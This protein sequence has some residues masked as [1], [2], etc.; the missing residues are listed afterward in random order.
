MFLIFIVGFI[1]DSTKKIDVLPDEA[2]SLDV[3]SQA[4]VQGFERELIEAVGV[5]TKNELAENLFYFAKT[6]YKKYSN[7]DVPVGFLVESLE[8][9]ENRIEISGRFGASKNK[10]KINGDI[11]KNGKLYLSIVDTKTSLSFNASLPANSKRNQFIGKLPI[12]Q[13]T[14][15]ILYDQIKDS[16]IGGSNFAL[17]IIEV[18]KVIKESL[19][20]ADVSEDEIV[21]IPGG[22]ADSSGVFGGGL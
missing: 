19:G 12:E 1:S 14:Y 16:F 18:E 17:G 3:S 22:E 8:K 2:T 9:K 15:Y 6:G 20:I 13:E 21:V 5:I 7:S 10:I 11:L 4:Y